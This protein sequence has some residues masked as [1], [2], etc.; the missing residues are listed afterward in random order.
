[1]GMNKF[2]NY[3]L[4]LLLKRAKVVYRDIWTNKQVSQ[5]ESIIWKIDNIEK[6]L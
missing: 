2:L 3:L 1:M 5:I 6:F 4:T